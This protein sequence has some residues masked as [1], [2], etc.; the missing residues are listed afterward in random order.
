MG[1]DIF[2][3]DELLDYINNSIPEEPKCLQSL[4]L[5]TNKLGT[6][7]MMQVSWIQASFMQSLAKIANV[8]NYLEIG[9]FTGYS[10]LAMAMALPKEGQI[11]T[12]DHDERWAKIAK[13]HWEE[14][15]QEDK[16][17]LQLD[18][19]K[20]SLLKILKTGLKGKLDLIFIDADKRAFQ[21]YLDTSFELIK[22]G[23]IILI[24]NVLWQG[25]V[26][27]P[28]DTRENTRAIIK[29]NKAIKDDPRF[30]ISMLP[31]GDGIT[32][33]IKN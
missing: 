25:G 32:M 28:K 29:F 18:D 12:L 3:N 2:L 22:P 8:K 21:F 10:A 5:E 11:I 4:R 1:T 19:A 26:V 24:D 20:T 27:D 14:A 6:M 15:G 30:F 13:R 17:T 31:I 33:A 7:S 16:I 9:T 23:G